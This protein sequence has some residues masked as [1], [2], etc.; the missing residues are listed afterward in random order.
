[1]LDQLAV[2]QPENIHEFE[3]DVVAGRRQVPELTQMRSARRTKSATTLLLSS[4]DT[5]RSPFDGDRPARL[6]RVVQPGQG[7]RARGE[8]R[9]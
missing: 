7:L 9:R 1:M 2:G 6:L 8:R 4:V 3:L 5:P